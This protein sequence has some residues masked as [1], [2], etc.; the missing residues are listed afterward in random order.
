MMIDADQQERLARSRTVTELAR[1]RRDRNAW[2]LATL[3]AVAVMV[4]L[5]WGYKLAVDD[6]AAHVRVA[7]VKLLPNGDGY[8]EYLD[9]G[10]EADRYFDRAIDAALTNYLQWRFRVEPRTIRTD[11]GN[12][13]TFLGPAETQKFLKDFGAARRAAEAEGC[14]SCPTTDVTVRALNHTLL[15]P[16]EGARAAVYKTAAFLTQTDRDQAGG[17][18]TRRQLIV[19]LDWTLRP[20]AEAGRDLTRLA[21]N[22]PAIEIISQDIRVDQAG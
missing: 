4:P 1:L 16:A 13:S 15:R 6:Y 3:A 10:G 2:R 19:T 7:W 20:A 17:V 21:I 18:V 8:A 5:A 9:D 14:V 22:P 12:A 11:Y